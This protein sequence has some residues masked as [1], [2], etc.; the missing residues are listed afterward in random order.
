MEDAIP[1]KAWRPFS[2]LYVLGALLREAAVLAASCMRDVFEWRWGT[3]KKDEEAFAVKIFDR[4]LVAPGGAG[5][6]RGPAHVSLA[7]SGAVG[8]VGGAPGSAGALRSSRGR[9]PEET[10]AARESRESSLSM[11]TGKEENRRLNR[12]AR[13]NEREGP[14]EWEGRAKRGFTKASLPSNEAGQRTR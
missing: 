2:F 14:T 1:V 3:G 7:L 8:G 5:E 6:G 4:K 11:P 9:L 12:A 13:G 10:D